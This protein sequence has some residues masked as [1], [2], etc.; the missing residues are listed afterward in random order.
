MNKV[1]V[2][3]QCWI[4]DTELNLGVGKVSE[5][6]H[7]Q[8]TLTFPSCAETRIYSAENAPLTRVSFAAGDKI[9]TQDHQ[10][11]LVLSV[12]SKNSLVSYQLID[13][14]QNTF[15]LCE[16]EFNP[17]VQTN[18]ALERL[19]NG[20]IDQNKQFE[21]R[22]LSFLHRNQLSCSP[23]SG[24]LG[25][26][27]S[28]LSH[29]LYIIHEI[30]SRHAPRVLL[31]DEVG[32]GKTIEAGGI[33]H[34]QAHSGKVS[35]ILIVVPETLIHQ[36][37]VEMKRKFNLTFSL[38][39]EERC[40]AEEESDSLEN[41]FEV[42][43]YV[44]CS[45]SLLLSQEKRLQQCL[46]S[47]WDMLV[48]DEA[49][50]L[51]WSTT[52]SNPEYQCIEQLSQKIE[53]VLLLT[54]TPEQL[55]KE[56]HFA[57]LRLL[58]PDRFYDFEDYLKEEQSYQPL[59]NI[60]EKIYQQINDE[61]IDLST[62]DCLLLEKL[63]SN[64]HLSHQLMQKSAV[65]A[66]NRLLQ[67]IELID[68]LLDYHGTGRVL[69]R[70]TRQAMS[71]FP[72][73][74]AFAYEFSL[75]EAY[76]QLADTA[77]LP[78]QQQNLSAI[79]QYYQQTK[80]KKQKNWTEIDPRVKWLIDLLAQ[81]KNEK[82]VLI[83][84]TAASAEQ[85]NQYLKLQ[86]I[87]TST[88]FHEG[89]TLVERDKSAA[90]FADLSSK[91]QL[92]ICSEI[93]SEGRNFQFS[94]HLV[95]FDLPLHP[96][97][98]EQRIGRL[99]RIGQKN[100][101]HLHI[102]YFKDSTLDILYQWYDKGLQI[103][104][105]CNPAGFHVF[106]V[107]KKELLSLLMSTQNSLNSSAKKTF[108]TLLTQTQ[109]LS[110]NYNQQLEQGRDRL[111]EFNSCRTQSAAK[112][113]SQLQQ[114][115]NKRDLLDYLERAFDCFGLESNDFKDDSFILKE[116]DEMQQTFQQIPSNGLIYTLNREMA[117]SNE[118]IEF[119][120]WEHPLVDDIMDRIIHDNIGNTAIATFSHPKFKAGTL[121]LESYFTLELPHEANYHDSPL[122]RFSLRCLVDN[123][124]NNRNA[125]ISFKQINS[126]VSTLD[127]QAIKAI[128]TAY[129]ANLRE[130]HATSLA[131]AKTQINKQL[132]SIIDEYLHNI[133]LEISRLQA[134]KIKN[135][136]VRDSEILVLKDKLKHIKN[137]S[138]QVSLQLD[139]LRV[140]VAI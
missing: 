104:N 111:L 107:V 44:L 112:I 11:F 57:R 137:I 77:D 105:H 76:Q 63:T 71:N 122:Q 30:A 98:L 56:S 70:N 67:R 99:D 79:E 103:F 75:P 19:F 90:Y 88:V 7:R 109:Q 83:T 45:L 17:I 136:L 24:M 101:I 91:C 49:H 119:F 48:V 138:Q 25:G 120:T 134:L 27:I 53:S 82:I 6:Q 86:T 87:V 125:D 2:S 26:R 51:Q 72:Q 74:K 3:G 117:L 13:Q 115:E 47:D 42:A 5:V 80:N 102:P 12:S 85:L 52:N 81:L 127:K 94:S 135:S 40:L 14:K 128:I 41:P 55:G 8:V 39:D 43:Q 9:N 36:W 21:A 93:G 32:L 123:E 60:V 110:I 68:Q 113:I 89:K 69:F 66:E 96:D 58:D 130:I 1:F 100:T 65:S 22:V 38:L 124:L 61:Q 92:L 95:L 133:K 29:Q 35:R 10:Q 54:A 34:Q 15:T 140:L 108:K 129:A 64:T 28:L 78:I 116:T 106:E 139:A 126:S 16:S 50:H 20:Q 37:L 33:I 114:A 132:E 59:A 31:A 73:R 18:K 4:S 46:D 121:L 84:A 23:V 62:E 118:D 97:L 131:I